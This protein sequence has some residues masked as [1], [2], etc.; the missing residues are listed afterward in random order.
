MS[1]IEKIRGIIGFDDEDLY[2]NKRGEFSEKQLLAIETSDTLM[3]RIIISL[4]VVIGGV[5]GFLLYSGFKDPR[6]PHFWIWGG[7]TALIFFYLL[8]AVLNPKKDV[9][10]K[11]EGEV[12]FIKVAKQT[13]TVADKEIDRDTYYVYEMWVGETWFSSGDANLI[14]HMEGGSFTVFYNTA[15][16]RLLSVE[17][18]AG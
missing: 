8:W 5:S 17:E 16:G 15:T 14:P 18:L 2:T 9:V 1:N 12:K 10:A 11:A 4:L 7:I 13:G 6:N 3:Y